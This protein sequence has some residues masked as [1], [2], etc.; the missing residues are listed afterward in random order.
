MI[1]R[2]VPVSN[3]PSGADR[4]R[5]QWL[6]LAVIAALVVVFFAYRGWR[7]IEQ[8]APPES[9]TGGA[10][11][12]V[13]SKAAGGTRTP[14][15]MRP[16]FDVVRISRGGTGVIAGR[17]APGSLVEILVNGE[18][19]GEVRADERG[20][21]VFILE[22]PL[23]PGNAEL[24]LKAMVAGAKPADRQTGSGAGGAPPASAREVKSDDVV[25][26]SIPESAE[27]Q[28]FAAD[29]RN[30]VVAVL[31]PRNGEGPSRVMQKP[32]MG[33]PGEIGEQ[34]AV[35]TVDYGADGRTIFTGRG[36]PRSTVRVYLDNGFIGE[37][38]VGDE[39][40]WQVATDLPLAAGEHMLRTDQLLAGSDAVELRILQPFTAGEVIDPS[41]AQQRVVVRPGNTLW[42][43]AR[44]LYGRGIRYTLIF[45]ENSEQIADPD[46]I[47]P[48]QLFKVP[49]A[50]DETGQGKEDNA[51]A[52]VSPAPAST[53]APAPRQEGERP[54]SPPG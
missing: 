48:G 54:S 45:Q 15:D 5:W 33:V 39:G 6:A 41:R 14:A 2:P 49:K 3:E 53:P 30:G 44:K 31:T 20:E 26:V 19:V 35:D 13:A 11:G 38:K 10:S 37:T 42:A 7:A 24:S 9:V 21:W 22:R 17:A 46:L 8:A 34:L 29:R 16:S 47:Y 36:V 51:P 23:A 28:R 1:E 4:R 43:I 12:E 40:H 18:K 27:E 52:A 25:V 50:R 32:G